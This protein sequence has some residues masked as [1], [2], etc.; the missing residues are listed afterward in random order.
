VLTQV[1]TGSGPGGPPPQP[2]ARPA[3]PTTGARAHRG[4]DAKATTATPTPPP[5]RAR[6]SANGNF[7]RATELAARDIARQWKDFA[8]E[9]VATYPENRRGER[10]VCALT[11]DA[12]VSGCR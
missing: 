8:A 3:A 7:R 12:P 4:G 6:R 2:H 10:M 5:P 11:H 1:L 9:L